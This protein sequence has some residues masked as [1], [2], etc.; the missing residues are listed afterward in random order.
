MASRMDVDVHVL[1]RWGIAIIVL[2]AFGTS[3]IFGQGGTATSLGTVRDTSG[4]L[5]PGVSIT[6][7]H[8]DSG[9]TR[10]VL[11]SET[12]NYVAPARPVGPYEVTA[13]IPGFK[14]QIRSAI[15][16]AAGQEAVIDM[17]L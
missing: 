13:M 10:P 1:G 4:A 17:T 5:I 3:L 9:L 8:T 2:I 6:I 12:G 14:Q 16:L 15:N 7:K 11:S